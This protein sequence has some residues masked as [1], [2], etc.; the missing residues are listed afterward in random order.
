MVSLKRLHSLYGTLCAQK[1]NNL[2]VL[3]EESDRVV[4]L[5]YGELIRKVD[6]FPTFSG[7]CVGIFCDGSF[8]SLLSIFAYTKANTQIAL[9][10]PMEDSAVLRKQIKSVR[11]SKL[12]GPVSLVSTYADCLV[13]S[14]EKNAHFMLFFTSGTTSASKAVALT[15]ESICSAAFNGSSLQP[16][17]EEDV[18]L[19]LLPYSHVFGFVCSMLWPFYCGAA[20]ALGRGPRHFFDD[21]AFYRPT[22]VSLVP[23]MAGFFALHQLFNPELKLILIGA[24]VLADPIIAAIRQMGIRLSYGYGLTETSSGIALSLEDD[25][26]AMTICPDYDVKIASDGEILVKSS[27]T[28]MQ[29]YFED[30]E[31]TKSSFTEDGYLKTG[32]LGNLDDQNRLHIVG[33]KK[34][35]LVLPSGNKIFLPEYEGE[36]ARMLNVKDDLAVVLSEKDQLVLAIHTGLS[37]QDIESGVKAFNKHHGRGEQINRIQYFSQPLP[38][39]QTGKIKRYDIKVD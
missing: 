17:K 32:D 8:D 30:E 18:L 23:Q 14:D 19:S 3:Y 7:G 20:I 6:E 31:K 38:K 37:P 21:F 12:I 22:A 16:L 35:I 34:E 24:G 11:V 27:T 29:G 10:N 13:D 28:M 36:L 15:E 26:R 2:A 1:A 33:R 9:L 5:T 39:T 4:K 25:P